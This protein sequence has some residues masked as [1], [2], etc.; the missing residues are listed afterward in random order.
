MADVNVKRIDALGEFR[1]RLVKFNRQLSEEFATME[2]KWRDLHDIWDD[3]MY[4]AF[5]NAL[6]EVTPGIK[7]Y[8][9]ATEQHESYLRVLIDKLKAVTEIRRPSS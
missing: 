6:G 1:A 9:A 3:D 8:L 7:R 2:R 4:D 5:G